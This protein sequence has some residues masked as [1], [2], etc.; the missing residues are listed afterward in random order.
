MSPGYSFL[1][2]GSVFH[3]EL[4]LEMAVTLKND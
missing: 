2:L 3:E 4:L 1:V